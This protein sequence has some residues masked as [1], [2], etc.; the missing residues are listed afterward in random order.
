MTI[1]REQLTE[2]VR[3]NENRITY[4]RKEIKELTLELEKAQ[5]EVNRLQSRIERKERIKLRLKSENDFINTEL[6]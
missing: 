5:E 4:K 6:L 2:K 1:T 3:A